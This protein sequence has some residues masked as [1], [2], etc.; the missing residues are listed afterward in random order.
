VI[1]SDFFGRFGRQVV[2]IT[3]CGG[4]TSLMW[5][6]AARSRNLKTLVTT[7]THTQRPD[8]ADRLFDY[9]IDA[10]A[11]RNGFSPTAGICFAGSLKTSCRAVS[12]LPQPVLE[13]LIPLFDRV[14]IEADGSR[15]KP[16]KAWAHYEPVI[17]ESTTITIGILPL[18]P[19]GKPVSEA[20]VHRLP[21]FTALTGAVEGDIIR[22]EHYVSVISGGTVGGAHSL[23]SMAYGKKILFFNQIEDNQGMENA[24]RISAMLPPDFLTGLSA[25]IAGSVHL[26]LAHQYQ[27]ADSICAPTVA[28]FKCSE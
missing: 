8:S 28:V 26:N 22:D 9:F 20:L 14:F 15:S 21:L 2:S 1:L 24:R 27:P 13:T 12:A 23:F 16:L 3:G 10:D 11:A 18:W 19:L 4:K 5:A 25:V 7:T 6:L 17:T